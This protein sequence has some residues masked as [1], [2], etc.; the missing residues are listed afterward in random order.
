MA[1][2]AVNRLTVER[3]EA[4][5]RLPAGHPNPAGARLRLDRLVAAELPRRL[6]A[7]L[8]PALPAGD[9]SFWLI[10][11]L[12]VDLA[13]DLAALDDTRV[14]GAWAGEVGAALARTLVRG[15]DGEGVLRFPDRASYVARFLADLAAGRAWGMWCYGGFEP[16]RSLPVGAALCEALLREPE[17]IAEV[18]GR[19]VQ[20]GELE[21][22]LAALSERSCERVLAAALPPG[23]AAAADRGLLGALAAQGLP[24]LDLGAL[25]RARLR[26]LSEVVARWPELRGAPGLAAGIEW[27]VGLAAALAG[28]RD[29]AGWLDDLGAGDLVT[30]AAAL[31]QVGLEALLPL[32]PAWRD[33]AGGD[34][35]WLRGVLRALAPERTA[36]AVAAEATS[37]AG[38]VSDF[39]GVFFLLPSW[40]A[41][42]FEALLDGIE[43]QDALGGPRARA[44]LRWLVLLKAFGR[45]R[46]EA[47]RRDP[48]LRL[49]AGLFAM[50]GGQ[51]D[52][53]KEGAKAPGRV[54]GDVASPRELLTAALAA[55]PA[56]AVAELA[57][58]QGLAAAIT[59][60]LPEHLSRLRRIAE[61]TPWSEEL[62]LGESDERYVLLRD[63]GNDYWLALEPVEG[64]TA[65]PAP[66]DDVTRAAQE[67]FLT[68]RRP[69]GPELA[70]LLL[71]T[72][73]PFSD[74]PSGL[75]RATALLG[76]ALLRHLA[77]R[78]MGFA[79]SSAEHLVTNFLAGT[80][81]VRLA[82]DGYRV[83]LPR[84]PLAVVARM[85]GA[86]GLR[87]EVPWLGGAAIETRLPDLLGAER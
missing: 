70:H 3:M 73:P 31:R 80:G 85:A 7:L 15:P 83:V 39:A 30:A 4:L 49:A 10:R 84:T 59:R 56:A 11:R 81:E 24:S 21:G 54:G 1:A 20:V 47:A 72:A 69:A 2:A 65:A 12:D 42:A 77:G 26:L 82:A 33:A 46:A 52:P 29:A 35:E 41:L 55:S 13:C 71:G 22:V 14:A 60:A 74:L 27:V 64:D 43:A 50:P 19:L 16:L 9:P 78:L 8:A 79:W 36:G 63:S 6:A 28:V 76:H 68:R 34:R 32:L 44:A 86:D 48:A 53:G 87:Y 17:A 67:R 58:A 61:E 66:V 40:Q 38:L 57:S 51:E 18:L 45:R 5:Y 75:D 62:T 37:T 23:A 25:A